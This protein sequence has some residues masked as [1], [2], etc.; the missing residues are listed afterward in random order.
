MKK[1]LVIDGNS[2]LNRAFYGIRLLTNKNGLYTNAVY[3][4]ANIIERQLEDLKP[5]Y[6][7]VAFDL[8]APTFRHKAYDG[9]KANRKGMPEELAVQLPYAKKCM[10][11]MGCKVL[12]V[13]GYEA[14]DILGTLAKMSANEGVEGYILTGDRDSLQLIGDLTKVLLVKTKETLCFDRALFNETYGVEPEQFV[15]VKALMGD[16]SDNIPGVAGIGEKTALKL[17]AEYGS[18]DSIYE[19]IDGAKISASVKEKLLKDKDNAYLSQMLARIDTDAPV[20]VTLE[21]CAYSGFLR[22]ELYALFVELEFLALIKRFGLEGITLTEKTDGEELTASADI[23]NS[24]II[25]SSPLEIASKLENKSAAVSLCEE[26]K[27]VFFDGKERLSCKMSEDALKIFDAARVSCY[28]AKTIYKTFALNGFSA[29]KIYMDV[30]LAA[31]V[32]DSTEGSF[33]LERLAFSQLGI[34]LNESTAIDGV[35][36][37]LAEIY[38]QKI[39]ESDNDYLLFEIEMPLALVLAEMEMCGICADVEG[40]KNYGLELSARAEELKERIYSFAGEEFNISSPHQAAS[41]KKY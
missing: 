22:E 41:V 19:K 10:E 7:V 38:E 17:I 40:I 28:D 37:E 2:I 26:N 18:I 13:E 32:L 16:T 27:L 24:P 34:A 11:N 5:D 20:G 12:S 14:D 8:K 4:M 39:A 33:S 36:F 21:D 35:I 6:C 23:L 31:Y 9:Y 29:P 3:G 1:L 15:D 25:E 30:M